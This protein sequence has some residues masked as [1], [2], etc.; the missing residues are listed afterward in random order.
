MKSRISQPWIP[1]ERID[2]VIQLEPAL[3]ILALTMGA[4][5]FWKILLRR[6]SE[7]R[8]QRLK[9]L[10][11]N[12]SWHLLIFA[13]LMCI[14]IVL[15]EYLAKYT[16][17]TRFRGYVGLALLFSGAVVI[18]KSWRIIVLEY[19]FF[20][21]MR[22]GVPVLLVNISTLLLSMILG[23]WIIAEVFE[24]QLAPL[25]ATSAV[26]SIIMGMALQDTLGNLFAGVALQFDKPYELGDWIEVNTGNQ[27]IIGQV[28]E[29][30]WRATVLAA[31]TDEAITL[32]N[33]VVAQAQISNYSLKTRPIIRS[34]VFRLDPNVHVEHAKATLLKAIK[35][36]EK[37]RSTPAPMVLITETHDSWLPFKLIYFVDD[38][39]SQWSI[40]DDVISRAVA[41]LH[42]Q[43][44]RLSPPR[45]HVESR[46]APGPEGTSPV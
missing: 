22:E 11:R 17:A 2:D 26:F 9:G 46:K 42:E 43:G 21:H 38:F 37:V 44:I 34:Q 36:V 5:I 33:R 25:V 24:V 29:I 16:G 39:G 27:K 1:I 14:Y 45:L 30:T 19:L 20:G 4:W 23:G 7:K 41:A 28:Q 12:L 40:S 13:V 32:P 35:S 31:L 3:L 10:F 15:H 18:I 8:H 6:V